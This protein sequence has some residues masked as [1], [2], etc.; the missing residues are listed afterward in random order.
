MLTLLLIGMLTLAFNTRSVS[1]E[2]GLVGYWKFDEGSG[3]TA[4]DSSGNGN[5]GTLYNGP[6]WITGRYGGGLRFDGVDDFVSVNDNYGLK[7]AT[8]I[9]L[10]VWLYLPSGADIVDQHFFSRCTPGGGSVYVLSTWDNIGHIWYAICTMDADLYVISNGVVQRD[11][12][13]HIAMTYDG[14]SLKLYIDGAFD[15]SASLTGS[16]LYSTD[17]ALNFGR[18][19]FWT[20]FNFN[21]ALDDARIYN[22]TLSQEEIQTDMGGI[23]IESIEPVQAVYGS[24]LVAGKLTVFQVNITSTYSS[25]QWVHLT[26]KWGKKDQTLTSYTMFMPVWHGPSTHYLPEDRTVQI[27]PEAGTFIASAKIEETGSIKET[28]DIPVKDTSGL[29]VLYVP[30]HFS[31]ERTPSYCEIKEEKIMADKFI[32]GT[33]PVA[34]LKYSSEVDWCGI[35]ITPIP[36]D[37]EQLR[38][39]RF[40]LTE[41]QLELFAKFGYDRVVAVVPSYHDPNDQ[42]S[43]WFKKWFPETCTYVWKMPSGAFGMYFWGAHVWVEE[44]YWD[45][46]AHEFGHTYKADHCSL[47]AYGYW[48]TDHR[49]IGSLENSMFCFM[50]TGRYWPECFRNLP[51][52]NRVWVCTDTYENI[53][54]ELK[55]GPDPE[56]LFMSGLAFTNGTVTLNPWYH[57]LEDTHA[58]D[59]QLGATGNYTVQF[60]D[61]ASE[62][63]AQTGFN[64]SFTHFNVTGFCFTV[65]YVN[66]TSQIRILHN[67]TVLASR[68]VSPNAPTVNILYP[69]ESEIFNSGENITISW[70]SNDQDGD[71]LTYTVLYTPDNGSTWIP[72]QTGV[73]QT[74]LNWTVPN[75]H[76]TNQCRIKVIA[77]D[78]VN[79]GEGSSNGTFTIFRH[80]IAT[81]NVLTAKTV[82]GEGYTLPINVTVQNNGNYTETLNLEIYANTTLI[83]TQALILTSGNSTTVTFTWNTTGVA[84]GNYTIM[85]E[86]TQLPEET[87][88]LDNTRIDGWVFVTVPGDINGDRFVNVLDYVLVKKAIPSYPGHPKWNPNADINSDGFVNVK[89]VV[90]T[91]SN[92]GKSW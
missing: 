77:T 30:V 39:M 76:P 74:S 56:T 23:W 87:D 15:S 64:M 51:P 31:F 86:A 63:L 36:L 4:A 47:P 41:S 89:D 83:H 88:T 29:R 45:D 92:I 80:D 8:E 11:R 65:P 21:G 16:I 14:T 72:I 84:K 85:A 50:S 7:P 52:K 32:L 66:N 38:F 91:K 2:S 34:E 6:T 60:L 75:D 46:V 13:T 1:S 44:G 82:V 73:T 28:G 35:S 20:M 58:P 5:T 27:L 19:P 59:I 70:T 57:L 40:L 79:T 43:N 48:V 68:I 81:T 22:R 69:N 9:T 49:R 90:L 12:W 61:N 18:K 17:D 42:T 10:E 24:P 62:L 26:L 53:T 67:E 71:P 54:K 33:Y 55:V 3:N 37:I 78:G 25:C